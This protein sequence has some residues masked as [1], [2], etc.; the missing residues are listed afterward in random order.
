[1]L[2]KFIFKKRREMLYAGYYTT[3]DSCWIK[4]SYDLEILKREWCFGMVIFEAP[5]LTYDE[6]QKRFP[7]NPDR[8]DIFNWLKENYQEIHRDG[9]PEDG[10]NNKFDAFIIN[11]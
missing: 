1:M 4:I 9:V 5:G 3:L 11:S 2:I 10:V 7:N 6:L 8:Y